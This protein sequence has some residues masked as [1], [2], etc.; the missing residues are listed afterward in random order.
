MSCKQLC[1]PALFSAT[2]SSIMWKSTSKRWSEKGAVFHCKRKANFTSMSIRPMSWFFR[3][4]KKSALTFWNKALISIKL[5]KRAT[6]QEVRYDG[7]IEIWR[8]SPSRHDRN[9]RDADRGCYC[10]ELTGRGRAFVS[11]T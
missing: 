11:G 8:A 9:D 6:L 10:R 5:R 3:P 2:S 4:D 7:S 1:A